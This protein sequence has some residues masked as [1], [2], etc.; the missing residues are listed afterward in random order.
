ME[1]YLISV[2]WLLI[3]PQKRGK[4]SIIL[5]GFDFVGKGRHPMTPFLRPF[6][7]WNKFLCF[8]LLY[9]SHTLGNKHSGHNNGIGLTCHSNQ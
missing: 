2:L 1:L 4:T 6:F 7:I 5:K 3:K 9:N 8:H